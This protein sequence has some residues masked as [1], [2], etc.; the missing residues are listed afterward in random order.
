MVIPRKRK[1]ATAQVG[2]GWNCV[3]SESEC[4]LPVL[5]APAGAVCF[6]RGLAVLDYF[7]YCLHTV[8]ASGASV[9]WPLLPGSRHRSFVPTIPILLRGPAAGPEDAP[10]QPFSPP[11]APPPLF[12]CFIL[13]YSLALILFE[14]NYYLWNWAAAT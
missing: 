1:N 13:I 2:C 3:I 11:L 5:S 10:L 6:C 7:G 4:L 12:F 14:S 8:G 9:F